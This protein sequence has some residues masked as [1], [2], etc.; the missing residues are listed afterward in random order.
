MMEMD[1]QFVLLGTGDEKYHSLLRMIGKSNRG[2]FS[3]HIVFDPKMAKRIYAGCDF[4]LVPS[5]YEPCGLAQMVALRYGTVPVVRATGGLA[6][7]VRDFDADPAAGNGFSFEPYTS[8]AL[9]EAV[10]RSM[11]VYQN[12]KKFSTLI[13]NAM[14]SNFSWKASAQK[15]IDLYEKIRS[16]SGV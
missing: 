6:D 1:C 3:I 10:K 12:Q 8:D 14:S 9:V 15:Y 5:Y 4:I 2:R 7:T 16:C 13:K 11:A